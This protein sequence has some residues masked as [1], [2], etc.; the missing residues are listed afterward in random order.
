M[1]W[2]LSTLDHASHWAVHM[3]AAM[4][5]YALTLGG[6]F[7]PPV[8]GLAVIGW[9]AS[10]LAPRQTPLRRSRLWGHLLL[11][12]LAIQ[13]FRF[14]T[15]G[16]GLGLALEFA[17]SLQWVRLWT[18]H[19]PKDDAQIALLA[20]L[21][22]IA[23]TVLT[24]S[25]TFG[26]VFIVF[27]LSTP[28]V[29]FINH[30]NRTVGQLPRG[31]RQRLER[32]QGFLTQRFVWSLGA[33]AIP[34]FVM[35]T[36]LF[37]A[38]PRVGLGFAA[39][40]S[41]RGQSTTGFSDNV[42]LGGFGTIRQD[43]RI[44]MR[45]FRDAKREPLRMRGTSFDYYDGRTWSQPFDPRRRLSWTGDTLW[46]R[47][48]KHRSKNDRIRVV[49]E[50]L[51]QPVLFVPP[52]AV[53]LRMERRMD[54][55][56]ARLSRTYRYPLTSLDGLRYDVDIAEPGPLRAS[57]PSRPVA[58]HLRIPEGH[59]RVVE[60]AK[61]V[62]GD[63][64]APE[65]KVE[66]LLTHL[67]D[68]KTYRYS[69]DLP[70]VAGRV[71]LDVFLFESK[72]GHC[73][74]FSTSLAVMLRA[75]GVPSRNVT[76]FVGGSVN[77]YGDYEVLRQADAHSWVEAFYGDR[78]QTLD[79][80][81]PSHAQMGP[82]EDWFSNFNAVMDAMRQRWSEYV[83]SYDRQK[84]FTALRRFARWWRRSDFGNGSSEP[85]AP[86]RQTVRSRPPLWLGGVA[87]IAMIAFFALRW[88]R[89]RST[90]PSVLDILDKRWAK[91]GQARPPAATQLQ[92][93]RKLVAQGLESP[94][95][96]QIVHEAMAVRFGPHH[97]PERESELRAR[98]ER[99]EVPRAHVDP[100]R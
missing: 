37:L 27:V 68:S 45:V 35:T 19:V 67:R 82:K 77:P 2:D 94:A 47:A 66:R 57:H 49:L 46:L 31:K 81:P 44:V 28:L 74:Y 96:E 20:F 79:P 84:Q 14:I 90:A 91:L 88:F 39:I 61:R 38:F 3:Y 51:D 95:F 80:T 30:L 21:H 11:V 92:H 42:T 71:P 29:L 89:N 55:T 86:E 85:D 12:H 24:T 75:V 99:A 41:D 4:G 23:G 26:A 78:W 17:A 98:I 10:L 58:R 9:F 53:A 8:I 83:V 33:L 48:P 15:G 36:T 72:A 40:K 63:A 64:T 60:L 54:I 87:V 97:D 43:T 18:R 6:D 52:D 1:R 22:L 59:E 16:P 34:T 73:E 100:A 93:V 62:V 65:Q 13:T 25:L 56:A 5:F 70:N 7:P 50:P 76:G 69:L 32:Q